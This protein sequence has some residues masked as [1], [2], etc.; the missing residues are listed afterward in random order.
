MNALDYSM[1][2]FGVNN[3]LKKSVGINRRDVKLWFLKFKRAL[4]MT[5]I[6]RYNFVKMM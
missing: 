3:F 1:K 2:D 6:H 5:Q 4:I